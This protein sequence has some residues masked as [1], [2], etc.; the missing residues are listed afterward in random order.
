M[1]PFS[2]D[3]PLAQALFRAGDAGRVHLED[4]LTAPEM[5]KAGQVANLMGVGRSAI[6]KYRHDGKIIALRGPAR[7]YR[8]PAWQLEHDGTIVDGI[9]QLVENCQGDAWTAYLHLVEASPTSP[10]TPL[11]EMLRQGHRDEVLSWIASA[12]RRRRRAAP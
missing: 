10:E 8:F 9:G 3:E 6:S 1:I 7:G 4:I 2:E 5:L 12:I 11:Y